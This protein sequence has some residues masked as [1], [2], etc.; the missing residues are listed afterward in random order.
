M[1]APLLEAHRADSFRSAGAPNLAYPLGDA[2]ILL[3][4]WKLA[5]S[6]ALERELARVIEANASHPSLGFAW[7]APGGMLATLFAFEKTKDPRWS[8]LYLRLFDA[9][10]RAWEWH[11]SL[12]CHLWL[13]DLYGVK[14]KRVSGLHGFPATLSCMLRGRALLSPERGAEL[15]QR[16]RRAVFA[17]AVREG[18]HVNWPLSAEALARPDAIVWRVQH[19]IGAPGIVNCL[20]SL[21]SDSETDALLLAAGELAWLA[22]P[23]R[24]LPSLCHGAPGTG[25]AFLKLYERS[26]DERWLAR[27]R[28][29]AMHAVAQADRGVSEHGQRKFSLW[30]GDLGLAAFLADCIRAR[31]DFPT[32]DVF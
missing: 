27:A 32:L 16:A 3:L 17:T 15:V 24:K 19:C 8:A 5:P 28:A 20:T 25:Y 4:H 21:P 30:T 22:G 7:G 23:P 9:L 2:G 26:G 14:E 18:A 12:G 11:E 6:A 10:W 13:H 31:A 29:F 1:L